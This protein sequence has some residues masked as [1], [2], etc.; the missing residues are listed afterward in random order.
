MS[1]EWHEIEG[2]NIRTGRDHA[3]ILETF[4][5][6]HMSGDSRRMDL[7]NGGEEKEK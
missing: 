5:V 6:L 2:Q 7:E 4:S 3:L 1:W